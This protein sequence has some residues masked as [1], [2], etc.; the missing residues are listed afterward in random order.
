MA[1]F[2][3]ALERY[4][5]ETE[6]FN[7]LVSGNVD[8][9]AGD[10]GTGKT[11]L[12]KILMKRYPDLL[13][14]TEVVPA[15]N[16]VGNPIFQRLNENDP[17]NEDQYITLW[18]GYFLSLGANWLLELYE[19]AWT[20]TMYRLDEVLRATGLR[21]S[22][23]SPSTIFSA[24]VNLFRRLT[25]PKSVDMAITISPEGLPLVVPHFEFGD[26]DGAV[27]LSDD[28][29]RHEDA[30][31][32]LNVALQEV[33]LSLWLIMDRLDEAFA[34]QPAAEVPALRALLRTYLDMLEFKQI[35][36]KLFLRKDLFRRVTAGG[37]VNLTHVNARRHE[38]VWDIESLSF[39]LERRFADNTEFMRAIGA[40]TDADA[41]GLT[42]PDQVDA[43]SR[44]PQTWTW[45]MSRV[46]DGNGVRPPRNLIDLVQKSRDA[47][48]RKEERESNEH[49]AGEPVI[50]SDSIKAGLSALSKQRVEDTLLAE[51]G[52]EAHMIDRFRGGKAE[53][54]LDSLAVA[55]RLQGDELESAIRF[56]ESIGFLEP[57]SGSYKIPI[58]Y[59]DGLGITQGKAFS[60][61]AG[62]TNEDDE[63]E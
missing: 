45:M 27:D 1:E 16:L 46:R 26:V 51:A 39:L 24:V 30:L 22:D 54:N 19:E 34:G 49:A 18:K 13:P 58:L 44:K 2:D 56:L 25:N 62:E 41:F 32:L 10:K 40:S 43:G 63:D 48:L 55:L 11:A 4:F 37:F 57:I 59:R 50:V 23:D 42:F 61:A 12:F 20:D 33:G 6:A 60:Q 31:G 7:M 53:H 47:A 14:D 9:I 29:I 5:V 17:Y 8:I 21:S 35:G 28:I 3:D 36:L 15:F 38:I 52:D